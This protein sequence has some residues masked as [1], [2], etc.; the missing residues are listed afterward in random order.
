MNEANADILEEIIQ[1]REENSTLKL[2]VKDLLAKLKFISG[3]RYATSQSEKMSPLQGTLFNEAEVEHDT[4]EKEDEP[5]KVGAHDR[6]RKKRKPLPE[7]LPRSI[8]KHDL[9]E[10]DKECPHGHGPMDS[11]GV[12]VSEQLEYEPA[13]FRVLR[14]ECATYG[15]PVCNEKKAAKIDHPEPLP[16]TM[17]TPSLLAHVA[18][19]KYC[20]HI[21]L[22]RQEEMLARHGIFISRTT[23][24]T[25]I[26]KIAD[27]LL[28]LITLI[29]EHIVSGDIL[30]MDETRLQVLSMPSKSPTS[31]SYVWVMIGGSEERKAV[32]FEFDPSRSGAVAERLLSEFSGYLQADGYGGYNAVCRREDIRRV[33]CLMHI[34]RPFKTAYEQLKDVGGGDIAKQALAYIQAIYNIEEE[35]KADSKIGRPAMTP[36]ERC[37]LRQAKTAQVLEEFH[38]FAHKHMNLIRPSSPTGKALEYCLG[39]WPHFIRFMEDGRL[40]V[41]NGRAERAIR[42]LAQGRRAWLFADTESGARASTILFSLVETAKLNGREPTAYLRYVF[43]RIDQATTLEALDALLPWN[44]PPPRSS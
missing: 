17:A 3:Q 40:E 19:A 5:V 16:G 2:E 18:G 4:A 24:A 23:L 7:H 36:E 26:I 38:S 42:P 20:D 15:C 30:Q 25:W 13:R 22:Y 27:R 12:T 11:T 29:H 31:H 1:L 9:A 28:P 33:G 6:K 44:T 8:L 21:P 39:E 41:D 34:R 35:A 43:E 32:Y 14:H 10:K 37:A